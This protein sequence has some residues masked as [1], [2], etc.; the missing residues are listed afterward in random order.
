[1]PNEA[2]GSFGIDALTRAINHLRADMV[3]SIEAMSARV[4][5]RLRAVEA[6]ICRLSE[7]QERNQSSIMATLDTL[8]EQVG[9]MRG[10][11]QAEA[12]EVKTKLDQMQATIDQLQQNANDPAKVD[13]LSQD[14]SN[15]QSDIRA[16]FT[17]EPAPEPVPN[18]NPEPTPARRRQ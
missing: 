18:P 10:D 6:G 15:L 7:R 4:E 12:Q 1:M 5:D 2:P 13:A 11:A 16:I 9:Q 17:G 8:A 14:L 3:R